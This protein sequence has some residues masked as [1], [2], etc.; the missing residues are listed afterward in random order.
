MATFF[1]V[2]LLRSLQKTASGAVSTRTYIGCTVN[3][4]RRIRQHNG[5]IKM[6]A[7]QT[8]RHRPW[9]M[10]LVCHGFPSLVAALQFEWAWQHPHVSKAVRETAKQLPARGKH[11]VSGK[12]RLLMEMLRLEKWRDLPL[13]VHFLSSKSLVHLSGTPPLPINMTWTVGP[14]TD[15]VINCPA[16][17][18]IDE[19]A[20]DAGNR[21]AVPNSD[22]LT[23]ITGSENVDDT[24]TSA[25]KPRRKRRTKAEMSQGAAPRASTCS[26]S[27]LPAAR[28]PTGRRVF[29]SD[30]SDPAAARVC[31][32]DPGELAKQERMVAAAEAV[33][34]EKVVAAAEFGPPS[35]GRPTRQALAARASAEQAH[36]AA[37]SA[38]QL[39][40]IMR[41]G[42]RTSSPQPDSRRSPSTGRRRTQQPSDRRSTS[43]IS[44]YSSGSEADASPCAEP[45]CPAAVEGERSPPPVA[46][47]PALPALDQPAQH[48]ALA[49]E[50][51]DSPRE[52]SPV[53][54]S[55]DSPQ[56]WTDLG[57]DLGTPAQPVMQRSAASPYCVDLVSDSS[58]QQSSPQRASPPPEVSTP[59]VQRLL[60]VGDQ[61]LSPSIACN[62]Q[63]GTPQQPRLGG[64]S[65]SGPCSMQL[66]T[67]LQPLPAGPRA[68]T[69]NVISL[70]T[71]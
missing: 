2:Y 17:C 63:L 67:P 37:L 15:L 28:A 10:I 22:V 21:D 4:Q 43:P 30:A 66:G 36:Q 70:L 55:L 65:P 54:A 11:L 52:L 58:S 39:L 23:D 3:P 32:S 51:M 18:D 19:N 27:P 45:Q 16:D 5:E 42:G 46:P 24:A 60:H 25:A 69:P 61:A 71:P 50:H 9:E 44:L 34:L 7:K 13:Q 31:S 68:R 40:E 62:M 26:R 38:R 33:A 41:S 8:S 12:V 14:L 29:S 59:A 56:S 57:T 48:P 1:A 53:C 35:P 64:V 47:P 6:G 49:R 20:L